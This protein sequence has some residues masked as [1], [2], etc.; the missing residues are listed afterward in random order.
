MVLGAPAAGRLGHDRY[1]PV[2]HAAKD[3][4]ARIM[5]GG[6]KTRE[7][8][9]LTLSLDFAAV[10]DGDMNTDDE[11][12][13]QRRVD[14]RIQRRVDESVEAKKCRPLT[15]VEIVPLRPPAEAPTAEAEM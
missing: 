10:D 5:V 1:P 15:A 13:I 6:E 12:E 11:K 3:H 8:H 7:L 2:T 4:E 9:Q 14:E